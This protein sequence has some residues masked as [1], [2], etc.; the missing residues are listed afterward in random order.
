M[1]D[2][3]RDLCE[4][5]LRKE[6][7][8]FRHACIHES[9]AKNHIWLEQYAINSWPRW[10]YSLEDATLTFSKDGLPKVMCRIEV[11][12]SIKGETWEWSWGNESLP[13]ACRRGMGRIH[14]FGEERQWV[15]LSTLFLESDEYVG[16][17]CA[18]IANHVLGGIGVYRCPHDRAP[19]D[20]VYV[21]IRSAEFVN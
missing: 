15:R 12:G 4:T 13:F 7:D 11:V 16:W 9:M 2:H 3:E 21:V 20:A 10:D 1:T 14:E 5:C 18:A 6:Y 17:E 19:R 8:E